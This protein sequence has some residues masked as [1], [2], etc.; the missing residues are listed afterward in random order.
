MSINIFVCLYLS[1]NA[2]DT[3]QWQTLVVGFNNPLQQVVTEHLKHHTHIWDGELRTNNIISLSLAHI[4]LHTNTQVIWS[5]YVCRWLQRS[6]S[7]LSVEPPCPCW[8]R[9][10]RSL[11]PGGEGDKEMKQTWQEEETEDKGQKKME[12]GKEEKRKDG[13]G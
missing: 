8:G 7:H 12:R 4:Q 1:D 5:G 13:C 9:R 10:G 11:S 6:W 3:W 2:L